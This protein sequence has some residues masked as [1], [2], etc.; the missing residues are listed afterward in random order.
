MPRPSRW[1][2]IV[3][4]AARLFQEKGFAS[5]SLEDIATEVGVWKGSLYHYIDSKEDL[6]L[7]VV[8][9]PAEQILAQIREIK[10]IDLPAAEKIR[11][12]ARGHART[13][14]ETFVYAS[15][16]LQEIAG[17]NR[18]GE[19]AD[20]DREYVT[21]ITEIM[22]AG[23]DAGDFSSHLDA[24]VAGLSMVGAFNWMTHWYRPEGPQ[25]A[26]EIADQICS[27]LLEGMISRSKPST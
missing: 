8:R 9:E 1:N 22:R 27:I 4:T 23:I 17:R 20:M 2:E 15:V 25:T 18:T 21:T 12:I 19:W 24:R 16:Y 7:A 11:R 5:T 3:D 26:I 10:M 13:L 6:L 14:D